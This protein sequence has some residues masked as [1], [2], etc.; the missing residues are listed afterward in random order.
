M[1]RWLTAL[2]PCAVSRITTEA[3][4]YSQGSGL[5]VPTKT[6]VACRITSTEGAEPVKERRTFYTMTAALL[7]LADWRQQ[8]GCTHVAIERTGG[9]WRPVSTL[10]EGPCA[11]L[12]VHAQPLK[13]VPAGKLM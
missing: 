10:L 2:G 6:G 9:S 12:V 3:S 8:A 13:A 4:K 1:S 7:A 11:W 5:D